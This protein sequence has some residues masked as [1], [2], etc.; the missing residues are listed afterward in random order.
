LLHVLAREFSD[1]TSV[2]LLT[3]A[4]LCTRRALLQTILFELDLPFRGLDEGEMRLSLHKHVRPAA[5]T[6]HRVLLLVDEAD[7]LPTRLLEELRVLTN[8]VAEG[9]PLV[10]VVLAGGPNL[11]ERFA[12]PQ[13]DC[14]SQ[15]LAARCYL[16]PLTREETLQ[17]V[18]SQAAAVGIKPA[19][20]FSPGCLE[21]IHQATDGNPRFINQLG[22]QLLLSAPQQAGHLLDAQ[23]VQR[24]WSEIQQLPAPWNHD[25]PAA[26]KGPASPTCQSQP[27]VTH[28]RPAE[29]APGEPSL[30]AETI[31]F[32]ELEE[33]PRE[34]VPP[35][36]DASAGL[37]EPPASIPFELRSVEEI[38]ELAVNPF[39]EA[40]EDEEILLDPYVSLE[41]S[42]FAAAPTTI[43]QIDTCFAA[44]L[45]RCQQAPRP[46]PARPP[47]QLA[48]DTRE[49]ECGPPA[50]DVLAH[51]VGATHPMPKLAV[52]PV[53]DLVDTELDEEELIPSRVS[54]DWV[55][56]SGD[57]GGRGFETPRPTAFQP[58]RID[59]AAT[60]PRSVD[61]PHRAAA[62]E[63]LLLVEEDDFN[64]QPVPSR[65]FR[66]LFSALETGQPLAPVR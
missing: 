19:Q 53:D 40:F 35:P 17:Y 2:A 50:G 59:Q 39:D 51:E 55:G 38:P 60:G 25:P 62:Q 52:D 63:E 65:Q 30:H 61:H 32:G 46:E 3:G 11:E 31:E 7:S 10:T 36:S 54:G 9:L 43:N 29:P 57:W 45:K 41:T 28:L 16:S 21:A 66:R 24:A 37:E 34:D 49:N 1:R 48:R 42:L 64:P 5:G 12:D 15:R 20:L 44:D 33:A 6:T 4:Q 58:A 27:T 56:R 26:M 14:F 22:D 23:D 18:R 8:V 13:L 47:L